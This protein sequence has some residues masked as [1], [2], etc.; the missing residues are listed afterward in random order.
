MKSKETI[1]AELTAC[2]LN[3]PKTAKN[4][5]ITPAGVYWYMKKYGMKITKKK[6]LD[7]TIAK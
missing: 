3:V 6:V 2:N 5:D 4:L 1:I 7:F